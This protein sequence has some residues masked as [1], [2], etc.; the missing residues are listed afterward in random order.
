MGN[1]LID[2]LLKLKR[3][4]FS[5]ILVFSFWLL[6]FGIFQFTEPPVTTE[7]AHV[8]LVSLGIREANNQTPF[9]GF[10]ALIWPILLEVIVF[11]FIFGALLEK[12]N[13]P[14]TCK[15]YAKRQKN[16]SVVIGYHH[17]GRR[18]VD[19]LKEHDKRFTVIESTVENIDDLIEAGEPVVA[20]DPSELINLKYAGIPACKEVF[21]VSNDISETIIVTEKIR[22]LNPECNLYVRIFAEYFQAYLSAP[23]LNAFVFS[24]TRWWM[25]CVKEWTREKT[26]SAIVVGHDHLAELITSHIGHEQN[27]QV[28]LID[29]S[30]EPEE[31]DVLN[32]HVFIVKDDA[33]R[34]RYI[35]KHINIEEVTQVFLCWK[36]EE[37]FSDSMYLASRFRKNYPEIE[38]YIRIFDD[39]LGRI[40]DDEDNITSFSTSL[41]AFKM[42]RRNVKPNSSLSFIVDGT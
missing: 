36:E 20:G 1:F 26:G 19:F 32:N 2:F 8:L 31:V 39:E 11:G 34:V 6:G 16:H 13:P 4:R 3:S 27:R 14:L 35:K 23:P 17:F 22:S 21:M 29:P 28:L 25:D 18:I 38:V 41:H 30:I 9:A 15:L 7:P 12:F 10:Y 5:F 42:L 40:V 33:N 37:E 24:T